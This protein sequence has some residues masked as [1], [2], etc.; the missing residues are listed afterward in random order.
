[1][2][3]TETHGTVEYTVSFDEDGMAVYQ[4]TQSAGAHVIPAPPSDVVI[5]G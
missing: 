2:I 4:D 1:M 5:G 3:Q